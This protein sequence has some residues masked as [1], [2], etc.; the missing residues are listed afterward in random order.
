M[1]PVNR[2][3]PDR[4]PG[5][6]RPWPAEDGLLV[7]LRLPGGR[8]SS[9]QLSALMAV[10]EH[11]GDGR[12]HL[13]SR[14]N[15]QLR[16]MP[17]VADTTR[18]TD[19]ALAAIEATGLVPSR[20]HDVSRNVMASPQ[21]GLSG[22]RADLRPVIAALDA[23]LCAD[24]Q[25]AQLPGRFL[26]VLDDGRGDMLARPCDLGLVA[27]GHDSAQIRVGEGWGPTV[28]LANAHLCLTQLAGRFLARRGEGPSAA[29]HVNELATKLV[30]PQPA[31][32]DVPT[33]KPALNFGPVPGG[34]HL[35][36]P[37]TG[38][39]RPTIDTLC[40]AAPELIVTP[41]RGVLIPKET[42]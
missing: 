15:I 30:D 34:F 11:Y 35:A 23:A 5:V 12:I 25:F 21:T 40:A 7:R 4:C 8:V 26:F 31:D 19:E 3:R 36:V 37:A 13:T 41:W 39:D 29:W 24:P 14:T 27:L 6:L 38:L 9:A 22:G 28:A 32:A 20:S 18:L 10:A 1:I 42:R 16:A 2:I 17:A 33:S